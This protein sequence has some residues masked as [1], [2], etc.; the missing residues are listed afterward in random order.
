MPGE[1]SVIYIYE[2]SNNLLTCKKEREVTCTFLCENDVFVSRSSG[3]RKS[4]CFAMLPL[5]TIA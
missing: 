4:V 5:V 1:V 3:Y 2:V